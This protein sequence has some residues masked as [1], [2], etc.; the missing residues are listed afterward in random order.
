MQ[1]RNLPLPEGRLTL[2]VPTSI[3]HIGTGSRTVNRED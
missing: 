1:V 2:L 3:I